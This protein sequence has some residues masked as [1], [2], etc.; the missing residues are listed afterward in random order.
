VAI[1]G[2]P[3]HVMLV[4]FP[5]ALTCATLGS[6]LFYWWSGDPFFA[7]V[8]L[9]TAGWGFALGVLAALSGTAE[10]VL[11]PDIRRRTEVWVHAI[12]AMMVLAVIGANW[13]L[14]WLVGV[15]TVLP[16]GLFLSILGFGAVAL[17]GWH[18]GQL[19]FEHQVGLAL[20]NKS[21]SPPGVEKTEGSQSV[22]TEGSARTK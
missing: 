1:A 15:E 11:V 6:D 9:W 21:D 12:A 4:T 13:A 17:A 19:I 16:W 10:M 20:D 8:S 22:G 3:V 5:I 7:R 14:R 18:G 2:H